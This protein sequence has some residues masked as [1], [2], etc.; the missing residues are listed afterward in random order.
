MRGDGIRPR[1]DRTPL[2]PRK[3]NAGYFLRD[4]PI[5]DAFG[6][7][8]AWARRIRSED[9]SRMLYLNLLPNYVSPRDLHADSY[10][11][12]IRRFI[13]E[14][15]L[16]LVSFDH[17]P[18]TFDG[19]RP[20]FYANLEDIAAESRRAGVPFWAFALATAHDPYP[21][22]TRASLRLQVFSNLAYGAQGI[23]YFTYTSPGTEVWNFHNAPI[24]HEGL[25]T[26]VYDLLREINGCIHA[27]EDVFLGARTLWVGHTGS[28]IPQG[29]RPL[30]QLPP[31]IRRVEADGQGVLVSL[32]QNGGKRYL[33]IVNRDLGREQRVTVET[34]DGVRRVMPD[35]S[36]TDASRY[37]QTLAVEAGDMLLFE[38][39]D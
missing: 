21:A 30:G 25:R 3:D 5:C 2:P 38:L 33:M 26:E 15:G 35:G 23:Q 4:E 36:R 8:A 39:P 37:A 13:D 19:L 12:Y 29:T 18:V 14:V 9:D 7:L 34:T 31:Q 10:A 11:D 16:G 32:L 22:A 17:Y 6:E 28:T 20:E 24:D 27:L 1:G